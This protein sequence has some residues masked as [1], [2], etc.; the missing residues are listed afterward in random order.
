MVLVVHVRSSHALLLVV[1]PFAVPH[2][3]CAILRYP[4]GKVLLLL[5]ERIVSK[6]CCVVTLSPPEGTLPA[7]PAVACL[8]LLMLLVKTL[9][10]TVS[11]TLF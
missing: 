5:G 8:V 3:P 7:D 6:I 11:G 10:V 4:L 2:W 1:S 9:N